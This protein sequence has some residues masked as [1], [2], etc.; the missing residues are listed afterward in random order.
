MEMEVF[1]CIDVHLLHRFKTSSFGGLNTM[2]SG[3]RLVT[4]ALLESLGNINFPMDE[5]SRRWTFS[6]CPDIPSG[7]SVD[8]FASDVCGIAEYYEMNMRAV[9]V[10]DLVIDRF[11][12]LTLPL[13]RYSQATRSITG[14]LQ[15]LSGSGDYDAFTK[16]AVNRVAVGRCPRAPWFRLALHHIPSPFVFRGIEICLRFHPD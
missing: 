4:A 12:A 9:I 3:G 8:E 13:V 10:S 11:C 14:W 16:L 7:N 6:Q 1:G 5:L 15:S 2:S